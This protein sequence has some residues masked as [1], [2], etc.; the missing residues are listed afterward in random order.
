MEGDRWE[1]NFKYI[2]HGRKGESVGG[3]EGRKEGRKGGREGGR[4]GG[5]IHRC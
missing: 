1:G 5:T 4:E 2:N 3:G